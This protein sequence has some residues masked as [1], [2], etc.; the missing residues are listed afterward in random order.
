MTARR[1][2]ALVALQAALAGVAGIAG[3]EAH[4]NPHWP[5]D[6]FPTLALWD[7]PQRLLTETAE[8]KL[9]E[10]RPV[11]EGYVRAGGGLA[12]EAAGAD[13]GARLNALYDAVVRTLYAD[14]SLGGAAFDLFEGDL[15][16]DVVDTAGP[17]GAAAVHLE[18][19]LELRVII[20]TA[21]GDPSAA[22]P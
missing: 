17:D 11:V 10:L 19:R 20:Q 2:T 1:E 13:A 7:G 4:R 12:V 21:V 15:D 9:Y 22:A 18:F 8:L 6:K 14:R 5:I 16:W 3:L